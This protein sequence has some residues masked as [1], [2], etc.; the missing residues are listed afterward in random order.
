MQ[1]E[2]TQ[3][4]EIK[5]VSKFFIESNE[6]LFTCPHCKS[7]RGIDNELGVIEKLAGEQYQDNLCDGWFEV[8]QNPII[9]NDIEKI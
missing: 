1:F 2:K 3:S 9:V 7:I 4:D 6:F 8:D 5:P